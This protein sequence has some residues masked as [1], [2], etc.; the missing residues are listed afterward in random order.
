MTPG[1]MPV[2][3][4][5]SGFLISLLFSLSSPVSAQER[6]EISG[7]VIDAVSENP[8]QNVRVESQTEAVTTGPDGRF[9]LKVPEGD[10][11]L[12]FFA[13]GYLETAISVESSELEV[14][15]FSN[16]FV[17]TV[18]VVP[19]VVSE[20][21][22]SASVVS[23][24]QVFQVAGSIDNV[25]RTLDTMPGVASTD[26]FGSRLAV[27]GGTPDQNLTVMDGI[28][29]HNPYRLFG[30]TSAFN[31]E[32]VNKFELT[33][34][35]FGVAYGDRLSSLLIVDNRRGNREF[36]GTTSLSIT[37]GNIV[38]EGPTPI[39]GNG[40]WLLSARRTYYDLVAGRIQNQNFPSFTDLQLQAGWDFEGGHQLT[41]TGLRSFEDASLDIE[42]DHPGERASFGS[43]IKNNL[44]SA[45]FDAVLGTHATSTTIVSWYRNREFLDF[46]G[47]IRA[48][49]KRSNT[50]ND[51]IAFGT[52]N[53][54]FDRL[55]SV[56]DVS[57]RQE[58]SVQATPTH[59][60]SAGF[61]LHHLNTGVGFTSSG[62]RNESEA[63]GSSI[64]G[65]TGLPGRLESLLEGTRGGLW[66]QDIYQPS[67]RLSIEPGLRVDWSTVNGH[68]TVSP[69]VAASYNLGERT[70]M[71]MA[72]GLY[73]Q[74]PGYE[75][76][77]QSDY[78]IDLSAT[79][80]LG[81][82]HEQAT[83]MVVGLKQDFG[84]DF[85]A[86]V[87]GYYKRFENLLVG[88]LETEHERLQRIGQYDFPDY[89]QDS[90]PM[91]PRITSNPTNE[92]GG[93][94]Y[95][96]DVFLNHTNAGAPLTGWLSYTWGRA[97]RETYG[98]RY[99][100]EYDRRHAFNAVGRY[101]ITNRWQVAGTARI[102][103]G[104]AYTAPKG[105]R[106][107]ATQ[108]TLGRLVPEI[109]SAGALVYTVDYGGIENLNTGR[110]PHYAR[111]D[112]RVTYQPGGPNGRWSLYV[113][114]INLLGRDNPI[115][116]ESR[117]AH[118]PSSDLPRL[119]EVPSQ[120][121]PRLPTFGF[122]LRF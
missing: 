88:R 33:A 41:F 2:D 59:L 36:Q 44:A 83:H 116:L 66:V 81:L 5:L 122:R 53:I 87:E 32:T 47:T 62:D 109:D 115:D 24:E 103:S 50:P 57:I 30:I 55:I 107:S 70:Q 58:F 10:R 80:E 54:V 45:R 4:I 25:F 91:T 51:D 86:R 100:F 74:S 112:L 6:Q 31:P 117:L 108:D 77:I 37:D 22:P 85:S 29:I 21:R 9:A 34:G 111:I 93:Q 38:L 104:F 97:N 120:G 98:R 65:G 46:N 17:E 78:F 14:R 90:V 89:L 118:D 119:R 23:S 60:V 99:P 95:G 49:A 7:V 113:E 48:N 72:V 94:A 68:A 110:L 75:K 39:W 8:I 106:V 61:E 84:A 96:F 121:F 67:S 28:E 76:L 35:G 20:E 42:G 40:S 15:L 64:L 102:A 43:D 92:A 71:R 18:Q 63:N 101:R 16:T 114:V 12:K 82:R 52:A 3:K 1:F 73:T 27:R 11:S 79:R 69:R 26:D 105:L 19:E 13:E 56:R